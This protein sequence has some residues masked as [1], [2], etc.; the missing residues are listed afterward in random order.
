MTEDITFYFDAQRL[1]YL[2]SDQNVTMVINGESGNEISPIANCL[3]QIQPGVFL[4]TSTIYSLTVTNI[5]A[6]TANLYLAA[7]E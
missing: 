2:E 3:C 1:V 5:S 4:R 6:S 7:V